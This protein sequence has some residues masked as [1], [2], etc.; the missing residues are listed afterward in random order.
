MVDSRDGGVA[1]EVRT[2]LP[3]VALPLPPS[4]RNRL[5]VDLPPASPVVISAA[6]LVAV[7]ALILELSVVRIAGVVAVAALAT[8][9]LLHRSLGPPSRRLWCD[10]VLVIGTGLAVLTV[11]GAGL[12]AS[13]YPTW[14]T[15]ATLVAYPILTRALLRLSDA[16]LPGRDADVLVEGG[17]AALAVGTVLWL[18]VGGVA[19]GTAGT[20]LLPIAITGLD[21][22]VLA[23]TARLALLPGQRINSS[24]SLPPA[25]GSLCGAN[26]TL[27]LP[28]G[29]GRHGLG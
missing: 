5:R 20:V 9:A 2:P 10:P 6:A 19:D 21:V 1:G 25:A 14:C 23:I 24:P 12:P 26:L 13:G 18:C 27:A 4:W 11:T 22:G 15:A 8:G 7:V 28:L 3:T 16:R 17:L 29:G